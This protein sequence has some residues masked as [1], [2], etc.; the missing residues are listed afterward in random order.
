MAAHRYPAVCVVLFLFFHLFKIYSSSELD[1]DLSDDI[2]F[3]SGNYQKLKVGA[4]LP[5]RYLLYDVN[6]GEGFNLRRDVYMR[7]ANLVQRLQQDGDWVLVLPPW[8]RLYH[9]RTRS[10]EQIRIPWGT[11]FDTE[12]LNRYVPVI[13]FEQYV[14][15]T[16][17]A[18]IDQILY[19]QPYKEGWTNGKWEEKID[20]RECI[21]PPA[22]RP[23]E[24]GMYRGWFWG[25]SDTYAK[26]FKCLSVQGMARILAPVLLNNYTAR[27]VFVDRGEEILHDYYGQVQYWNARRSMRFAKHLR[28]IGNQFR[29]SHLDSTDKKDKTVL[30]EDWR[31]MERKPGSAVGGPYLAAH[32]R[33]EDY[34]RGNRKD[35]PS[36]Q[37]AAEQITAA[38]KKH[39]LQKVFIATDAPK[40][41]I[42]ELKRHLQDYRVYNYLPPKGILEN[43]KDGGVAIIDQWICAHARYFI[44]TGVSTFSFRIHEERQILGFDPKMTYNRFCGDGE[45]SNCEQP[46]VWKVVYH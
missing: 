28:D 29:E 44:G 37:S 36:L 2:A 8:G 14:K 1:V 42:E 16:G 22:Y 35:V 21:E 11:F 4:A 45:S 43:F 27:S 39:K 10:L 31:D 25:H 18:V 12:S 33:R 23:D 19:L 24:E 26:A 34:A 17:R 20:E 9:W 46:S 38:L 3:H 6:H 5:R 41:E 13:E 40:H 7:I 30:L 32:L 15:E